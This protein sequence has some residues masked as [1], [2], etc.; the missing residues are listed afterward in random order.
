[1]KTKITLDI[2]WEPQD[3]IEDHVDEDEAI[4]DQQDLFEFVIATLRGNI[5]YDNLPIKI[6]HASID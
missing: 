6:V 1:M 2:E 4:V 3:P 5:Q